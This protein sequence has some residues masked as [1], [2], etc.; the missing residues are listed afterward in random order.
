MKIGIFGGSFNPPHEM[1]KKIALELIT[2]KIVDKVIYVPT[3]DRYEKKDLIKAKDRY[4]MLKLLT[5]NYENLEVSDYELKNSLVYTY[6]TLT[7]FKTK[8]PQDELYFICGTDNLKELPTWKNY[9]FLQKNFKFIIIPRNNDNLEELFQNQKVDHSN[10]MI[11]NL[12]LDDISS[13]KIRESIKQ[14]RTLKKLYKK[15]DP[16]IIKY[17]DQKNLYK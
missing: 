15:I 6:Q 5:E 2:N 7:Y 14:E 13:T 3:G 10:F 1:H 11:A 12:P 16:N 17:I 8:Y 9:H 4:E